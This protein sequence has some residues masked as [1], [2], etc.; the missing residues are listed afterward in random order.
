MI[1]C[2]SNTKPAD[3][4]KP[5]G[6]TALTEQQMIFQQVQKLAQ[7]TPPSFAAT[8]LSGAKQRLARASSSMLVDPFAQPKPLPNVFTDNK[9][10]FGKMKR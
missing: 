1:M 6:S 2:K 3:P 5:M 8:E 10:A 4:F 9:G 7:A